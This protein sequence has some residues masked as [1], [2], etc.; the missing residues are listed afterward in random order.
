M[1]RYRAPGRIN[2]IGEHT[3]YNLGFVLPMAIDRD[4]VVTRTPRDDQQL[5][6]T[7]QELQDERTF[8]L[9]AL[10][11]QPQGHW[12]DYCIGVA[13]ELLAAGSSLA[14]AHLAIHSG[15]PVGAG[16]SSS[17]A[18]EVSTALALLDGAA[19][20]ALSLAQLCQ[21]A[22]A[23]FVGL[24]CGIMD[25]AISVIGAGRQ[26]SADRL[27]F[28]RDKAHPLADGR[29]GDGDGLGREARARVVS[30][31]DAGG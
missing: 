24:P 9:A 17:A 23:G 31:C 22:E 7:S 6:L 2:L 14:G 19:I 29:G 5:R 21:R 26:R 4:C 25:Q 27:P 28:A 11:D 12:T 15:V 10:P 8:R 18:L 3:D 20:D 13:R 30:L 1:S 16:L